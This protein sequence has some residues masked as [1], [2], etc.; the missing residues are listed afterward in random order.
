MSRVI[1]DETSSSKQ[2]L[3]S[4]VIYD[5]NLSDILYS[6]QM[7]MLSIKNKI[8]T[9]CVAQAP[10]YAKD[11]S[12]ALFLYVSCKRAHSHR[13]PPE[14][15]FSCSLPLF[16]TRLQLSPQTF[17]FLYFLL[18]TVIILLALLPNGEV[19]PA[20]LRISS[21][22]NQVRHHRLE[23]WNVIFVSLCHHVGTI[24]STRF[25][26]WFSYFLRPWFVAVQLCNQTD[27]AIKEPSEPTKAVGQN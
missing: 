21:A 13:F 17:D 2:S 15:L 26:V 16:H 7:F 8:R 22:V 9:S 14:S 23:S 24:G 5:C 3:C 18:L 25:Q 12:T 20:L 11:E 4:E 6:I 27:G 10:K 19:F 1:I